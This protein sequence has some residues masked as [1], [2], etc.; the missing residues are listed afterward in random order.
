MINVK[1]LPEK[2]PATEERK[3]GLSAFSNLKVG[4]KVGLGSGLILLFLV[5]VSVVAAFGL[6]GANTNFGDYRQLARQ[7]NQ[8]GRIQANLLSA[9]LGVK[10]YIL[11]GTD[12]AATIVTKRIGT[13]KELI[14][15]AETLFTDKVRIEKITAAEH[16]M[17]EYEAG[18]KQVIAFRSQRNAQ[19]D[20]M[21][22]LGPKSEKSLTKV[23]ESA[24]ADGDAQA[25]FLAGQ[26]LRHLLL[27]RL[28]S[29]RF[30]VDNQQASADRAV[31]ELTAFG[32]MAAHMQSELQN[33]TR[34]KLAQDVLGFSRAYQTAFDEVTKVIF[35]HNTV[36]K[37][38]L[39]RIGP[40]VAHD[41]E[42]IKLENKK[43]QD[44][45]G[46]T[47]TAAMNEAMW[48]A[49]IASA[50]AVALGL[51]FA[52]LV[53][54]AISRPIVAMTDAMGSLAEGDLE[55]VIPARGR[56]DEIG[57][58]S[59]AVQV[60]KDNAVEKVRLEA[61]QATRDKNLAEEK[62][63][64]QLKLADDLENSVKSVIQTIAGAATEMQATAEG[65]TATAQ[66]AG[67]QSTAVAGATERA[68]EN[69]QTVAAAS[70]ELSSSITEISRQV[71]GSREVTENAQATSKNATET[72]QK[73][74]DMAQKVGEVVSLIT[75]IASQTNLLALNATIEA[76]RAGE[77]GKG[78]AVVASEVKS[79]A[80]QTAKATEDISAQITG[81]Q[82]AT[83][84]SVKA[85]EDI[86]QVIDKLGET[87]TS[88]AAAV[89]EQSASTQE[90]SRNAQ[91]AA[92]GTLEVSSNIGSVQT[93]VTET[94]AAA[95]EVLSA[96]SELSQQSES[97]D[98]Q[99]DKFLDSI[100]AA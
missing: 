77:A 15:S 57:E 8:M 98:Q 96:A 13:L 2:K 40:I 87:S 23:M 34:Q 42:Q 51:L 30:L 61:E 33:P 35:A 22:S 69:V 94:G 70:E 64:A 43:A 53:G 84:D 26:T 74:A 72:I 36:I 88:I 19:V 60:F 20:K 9:R 16:Q 95:Q 24:F 67:Q 28:Y 85:I 97:L 89:E 99:M 63:Q 65:M 14:I 5:A 92:D 10:D 56:K 49:I 27:A 39:D 31:R 73:L 3:S 50:V 54:R 91:Q 4:V 68:S 93:A 52:A 75:D 44:T 83:E 78:F 59:I 18:F 82:T 1:M 66:Q 46:P 81:M 45:L 12:E 21:N 100:R 62:H 79:L 90:I 6:S 48:T 32:K 41:M 71:S 38:T 11:K 47:A 7:T 80:N 76:A 17:G 37:G 86:R 25:S 55:T 58:M 29:N